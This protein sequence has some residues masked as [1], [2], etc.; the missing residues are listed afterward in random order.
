[1][2]NFITFIFIFKNHPTLPTI[3]DLYEDQEFLYIAMEFCREELF[4][5]ILSQV[6]FPENECAIIIK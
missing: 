2:Y 5:R 4:D 3:Y 1:M 6:C